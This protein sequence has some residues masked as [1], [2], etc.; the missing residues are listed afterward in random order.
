M[1]KKVLGTN[2]YESVSLKPCDD[3]FLN[4]SK[5]HLI[6]LLSI[7]MDNR[8]RD[9]SHGIL[10]A[11]RITNFRYWPE[12]DRNAELIKHFEPVLMRAEVKVGEVLDQWT[13]LKSRPYQDP[14]IL[15][16]TSPAQRLI[17]SLA[18]SA[19]TYCIWLTLSFASLLQ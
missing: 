1:L 16:K 10:S 19:R 7:T 13:V 6:D 5:D 15:K 4:Q 2:Q 14:N 3:H 8:F 9:M 12:A 18:R 11:M 17:G